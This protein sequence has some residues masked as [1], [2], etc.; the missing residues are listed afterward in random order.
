M[1]IQMRSLVLKSVAKCRLYDL[2]EF[3]SV[4][5]NV[6]Q[7]HMP[8]AVPRAPRLLTVGTSLATA[9][10]QAHTSQ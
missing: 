4:L 7:K 2:Q 1:A 9:H 10:A 3:F 5:L 8:L 6:A